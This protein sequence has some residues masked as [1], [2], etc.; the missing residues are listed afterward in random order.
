M[1]ENLGE[2]ILQIQQMSRYQPPAHFKLFKSDKERGH[3]QLEYQFSHTN[4]TVAPNEVSIKYDK[5]ESMLFL[6]FHIH[7]HQLE[8]KKGKLKGKINTLRHGRMD[9]DDQNSSSLKSFSSHRSSFSSNA[10]AIE[11]TS[12]SPNFTEQE[13]AVHHNNGSSFLNVTVPHH[14]KSAMK[15]VNVTNY[16]NYKMPK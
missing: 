8:K 1:T 4:P 16:C 5:G 10:S 13:T 9:M 2:V 3:I 7:V 14:S 12:N 6:F 11:F 15:T